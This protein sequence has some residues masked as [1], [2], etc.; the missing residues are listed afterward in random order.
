MGWKL[1]LGPKLAGPCLLLSLN[2]PPPKV[3]PFLCRQHHCLE[4]FLLYLLFKVLHLT[5]A[6]VAAV[7]WTLEIGQWPERSSRPHGANI[8]VGRQTGVCHMVK[9]KKNKA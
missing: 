5:N 1:A 3:F 6:C 4:R 2:P 8:L 9:G 7:C